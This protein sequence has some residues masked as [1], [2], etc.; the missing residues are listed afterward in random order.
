MVTLNDP[1]RAA[2]LRRLRNHGVTHDPAM[3]TQPGS[4]DADGVRLPW[5]YEQVELGWNYRMDEMSAAL[6]LSQLGKLERFVARR[7]K[8]AA[9]YDEA[10]TPLAPVVR[11]IPRGEGRPVLHL[12]QVRVDFD[13]AGISRAEVMRRMTTAGVAT[14]VHY[15]PLYRQ[16]VFKARY[17]E[18]RLPEAEA[19]YAKALAL[20]LFPAMADNEVE[21]VAEVLASALGL[22]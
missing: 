17:G 5:I 4:L 20:P 21:Q 9:L 7:A 16:P 18:M 2:R 19:F 22:N 1:E 13:A 15:I 6:G 3:M 12:Y 14:Q 10:L 11:T 8:L